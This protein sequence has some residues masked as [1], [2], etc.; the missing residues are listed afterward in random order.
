MVEYSLN[1]RIS[2]PVPRPNRKG[3]IRHHICTLWGALEAKTL[4]IVALPENI[5]HIPYVSFAKI[6]GAFFG[7]PHNLDHSILHHYCGAQ[8]FGKLPFWDY[9]APTVPCEVKFS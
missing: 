2:H 8:Y 5:V 7:S 4:R 1:T 6:F 9:M 3:D